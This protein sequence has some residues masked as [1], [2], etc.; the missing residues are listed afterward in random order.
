MPPVLIDPLRGSYFDYASK[1]AQDGA[2]ELCPAPLDAAVL[3]KIQ[4]DALLVHRTLGLQ[5][6]SRS[7]FILDRQNTLYF[8]EVNTLPGMTKTSL[9]PKEALAM[10]MTFPELLERFIEL[11]L[12]K[13]QKNAL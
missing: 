13:E 2:R 1:Y 3:T 6:L 9:V 11:A 7:D 8:L 5:G 4:Q 12:Q 10:G